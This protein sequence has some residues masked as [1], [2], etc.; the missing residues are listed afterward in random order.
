MWR[1]VNDLLARKEPHKGNI[2]LT[3]DSVTVTRIRIE[4][5][6]PDI[7]WVEKPSSLDEGRTLT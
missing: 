2:L 6:I 3:L 1:I 4:S 5:R 7:E